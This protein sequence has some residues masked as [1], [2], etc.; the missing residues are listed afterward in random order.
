[1]PAECLICQSAQWSDG[2]YD[3]KVSMVSVPLRHG[4]GPP[5]AVTGRHSEELKRVLD[6]NSGFK[7]QP[8]VCLGWRRVLRDRWTSASE[9]MRCF[10]L[11]RSRFSQEMGLHTDPVLGEA[12]PKMLKRRRECHQNSAYYWCF[13]AASQLMR[14]TFTL[15]NVGAA[16]CNL[17]F[18]WVHLQV[19]IFPA[20]PIN[21]DFLCMLN[22]TELLWCCL[23]QLGSEVARRRVAC[24]LA[25]V[26]LMKRIHLL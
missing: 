8:R 19:E 21:T 4:P 13:P 12:V 20:W 2:R 17:Q 26:V 6:S 18:H 3:G 25:S 5:S 1:M 23:I 15:P 10:I 22:C 24:R 14:N 11:T 9:G 16:C 7:E